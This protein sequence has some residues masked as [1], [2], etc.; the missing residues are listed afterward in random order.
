[1]KA[2][3]PMAVV[4]S[5]VT[6]PAW[7]QKKPS[8]PTTTTPMLVDSSGQVIGRYIGNYVLINAVGKLAAFQVDLAPS[9][10]TW[11]MRNFPFFTSSDC[12]G[13]AYI[14][15]GYSPTKLAAYPSLEPTPRGFIQSGNLQPVNYQS[16]L[17]GNGCVVAT[18]TDNFVPADTILLP[19]PPLYVQ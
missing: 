6:C 11:I 12:T 8:S 13:Q 2:L 18:G 5:M 19:K 1:M 15:P 3:L 9:G 10:M 17:G 7:A 4:L 16:Y 14:P